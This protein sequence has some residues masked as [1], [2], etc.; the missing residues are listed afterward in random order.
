MVPALVAVA[1]TDL[2]T[3]APVCSITGVRSNEP[4]SARIDWTVLGPLE[5]SLRATRLGSG[6]GRTYTITVT[7]TDGD[8]NGSHAE[9]TV[10][11]PHDQ[12]R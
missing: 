11:V 10:V 1:A 2:V 7:C 8:G 12:R 3:A 9:T 4:V 5:V 6:P